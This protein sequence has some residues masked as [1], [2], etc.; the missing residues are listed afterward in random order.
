MEDRRMSTVGLAYEVAVVVYLH[1]RMEHCAQKRN[2][3]GLVG[4]KD[5]VAIAHVHVQQAKE[6][7]QALASFITEETQAV[8]EDGVVGSGENGVFA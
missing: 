1:E 3:V 8:V 7:R 4:V 6:S 2:R 5:A